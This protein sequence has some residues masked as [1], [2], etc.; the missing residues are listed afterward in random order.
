LPELPADDRGALTPKPQSPIEPATLE[1]VLGMHS[2]R[3]VDDRE[4]RRLGRR[5]L[6]RPATRDFE[7]VQ[8]RFDLMK[9]VVA[10]LVAGTHGEHGLP[11][12]S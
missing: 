10:D 8:F 12:R 11:R 1:K 7:P 6:L 2:R 9:G 5:G 4:G 3:V